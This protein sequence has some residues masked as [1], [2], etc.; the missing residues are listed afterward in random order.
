MKVELGGAAIDVGPKVVIT[1]LMVG[2]AAVAMV[3]SKNGA[4]IERVGTMCESSSRCLRI[5]VYR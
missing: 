2:A 4:Q 5:G 1:L 3:G